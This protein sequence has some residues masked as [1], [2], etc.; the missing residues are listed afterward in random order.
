MHALS[1]LLYEERSR[2]ESWSAVAN[3]LGRALVAL[4]NCW[5]SGEVRVHQEHRASAA[6][7]SALHT[8]AGTLTV[9]T[10]HQCALASPPG[11]MHT[12]G[13]SMAGISAREAGWDFYWCG[14]LTPMRE[15]C[16]LVRSRAVQAVALSASSYMSNS[17]RLAVRIA[18][19]RKECLRSKVPLIVGGK[20]SWPRQE[21]SMVRFSD[22]RDF[23]AYL[24]E[25]AHARTPAQA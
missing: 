21:R 19:V 12:L 11:E 20:G 25:R 7:A 14:S 23:A 6:L 15:L 10:A 24:T 1:A 8:I 16:A 18:V 5:A 17:E 13:L 2:S 22:F 9:G 4:G 3:S